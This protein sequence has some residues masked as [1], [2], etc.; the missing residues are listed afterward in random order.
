MK[1]FEDELRSAVRLCMI[2]FP[3]V[4][5]A[6][7]AG[8]LIAQTYISSNPASGLVLISP[9]VNN[10][11]LENLRGRDGPPLLA[12]KL[13]EFDFEP[14]FPIAVIANPERMRILGKA[15]RLVQEPEVD[16]FTVDDLEGQQA[17]KEVQNWL[18][19]LGI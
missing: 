12:T 16:K 13:T 17:F 7:S 9:P 2:P 10:T 11:E 5:F 15:N 3:P 18:D 1:W 8:S 14:Y 4:I 19:K 6:R